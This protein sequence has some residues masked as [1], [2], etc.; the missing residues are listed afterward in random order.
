MPSYAAQL[1]PESRWAVVTYV[2]V[3][4]HASL[5]AQDIAA[6]LKADEAKAAKAKPEDGE[7]PGRCRPR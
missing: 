1:L 3:L 2:R 6:Q 4:N 7:P 5:A